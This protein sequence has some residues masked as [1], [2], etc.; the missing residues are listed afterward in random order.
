MLVIT[1]DNFETIAAARGTVV[2]DCSAVWCPPCRTFAPI[3]AAAA[4]RRRDLTWGTID[5]EEQPQLAAALDIRAQPT[6]VVLR[7]GAVVHKHVGAMSAAKL[8][9]LL[10]R[11]TRG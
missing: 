7:D 1:R 2:I 9:E 3:F 8:D 11:V 6:I 5:T 10:D 4:E